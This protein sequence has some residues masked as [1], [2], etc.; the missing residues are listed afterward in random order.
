[1]EQVKSRLLLLVLVFSGL[2][3]NAQENPTWMLTRACP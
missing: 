2:F 3:A 1:M